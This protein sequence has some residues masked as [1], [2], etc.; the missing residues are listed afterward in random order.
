M[1]ENYQLRRIPRAGNP[2][3]EVRNAMLHE[4][5]ADPEFTED[6]SVLIRDRKE[7]RPHRGFC[8]RCGEHSKVNT[9][10][11]YCTEC[12]WDALQDPSWSHDE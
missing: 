4:I 9:R 10:F 7:S 1:N 6:L 3:S 12:N 5:E 2:D 8:P 11:P